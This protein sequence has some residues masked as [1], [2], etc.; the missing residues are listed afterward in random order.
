HLHDCSDC[1]RLERKLPGGSVSHWGIA[2][3]HGALR[4]LLSVHSRC[5]LHTRAVTYSLPAIRRLQPFRCLHDC[6]GC[7]RLE[8][9]AGWALHP[10]ES[11]AFSRRTPIAVIEGIEAERRSG[12]E[13]DHQFN[14]S[15]LLDGEVSRFGAV[16]NF[17]DIDPQL[18]L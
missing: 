3:F 2:P 9:F 17:S 14:F 5:G 10:L 8:R 12:L 4:G 6:S 11:A 1:Y 7:F 16:K 18:P 13:V 15:A